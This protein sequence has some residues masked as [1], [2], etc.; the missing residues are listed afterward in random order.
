MDIKYRIF[1]SFPYMNVSGT[2]C[3]YTQFM[4]QLKPE[5]DPHWSNI[6]RPQVKENNAIRFWRNKNEIHKIACTN[7]IYSEKNKEFF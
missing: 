5:I 3:V 2:N 1:F 7:V 4:Y 6:V